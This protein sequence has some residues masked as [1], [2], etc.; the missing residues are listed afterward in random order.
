M[1]KRIARC[2]ISVSDKNGVIEIAKFLSDNGVEI[3]STGGTKKTLEQQN[4]PVVNIQ[5]FTGAPEILGGRVKTL[6]PKVHG[7]L[8]GKLDDE[9]HLQQMQQNNIGSIDMLIVNLY[10]FEETVA[11]TDDDNE[12]IENI[13][14]GGPAMVRSAAKNFND[15]VVVTSP[16]QY[17]ALKEELQSSD[18]KTSYEYRR[19]LAASAFKRIAQYD[20]AISS[21]FNNNDDILQIDAVKV[22]ELRYGENSHQKASYYS[23]S[24]SGIVNAKQLQGKELSYNNLNDADAAYNLVMEFKRPACAIIKHANPCGV[25]IA[26]DSHQAFNE[27]FKVDSKSAFGGIVAIN[28]NVT[29]EL[30]EEIS[31]IFFEVIIA[32]AYSAEALEVLSKK[33]NLRLLQADFVSDNEKQVKSISGGF[34]VQD[35]DKADLKLQDLKLVSEAQVDDQEK[36]ELLLAMNICKHVK[37]NAITI[38][39]D[40]RLV[41]VGA[42]Q[43]SRVDSM[44]IACEKASNNKSVQGS[45]LASDAF[46]PFADNIEIAAKYGVKAIVA[47]GGSVRDQEVIDEVNKQGIALYFVETRHFKH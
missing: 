40:G 25:A 21:Y 30:A 9:M 45:Y 33:K 39:K 28:D 29:K 26:D 41:G 2:L 10:P 42:G 31:K 17:S 37:S 1:S 15:K 23:N 27:A 8:L 36:Q 7:A 44:Q 47:P 22:K 6:H 46:F 19:G 43:T 12:I 34:L 35:Q 14:I 5:D 13:D 4:I 38:V 24:S 18:F 3:V 16:S 11:R 32:K 20:I